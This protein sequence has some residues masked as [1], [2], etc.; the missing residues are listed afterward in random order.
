MSWLDREG[1]RLYHEVHE[2]PEGAPP[3]LLTHG[4]GASAAM[5]S[6][7]VGALS[8]RRRVVAWDLRGHARSDAPCDQALYSHDLALG[9]MAAVLDA[10]GAE[11]A[12]LCGMSLGGYLSLR[13]RLA[14]PE[15]V[16]ALVLVDTGPGFRRDS[17]RDGW[18]DYCERTAADLEERGLAVLHGRAELG[19]H[20][21]AR[22]VARAARGIMAQDDAAVIE[23]LES[24]DVPTLV[25][26]GSEDTD[27]LRAADYME[28]RIP[29]AR[30]VV[31]DGAGHAANVDEPE[32]F[33]RAVTDFL[34]EL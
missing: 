17:E 26:V 2:G 29:G 28:A 7:N 9:D 31:I 23:S 24:V 1:V 14:H 15:R 20:P 30:K 21:D 22:G 8:E 16:A 19:D 5:W 6:A 4:F 27:F 10:A 18:N 32:A 13:F 11:R 3:I 12:V 33:N 25:V 34:E